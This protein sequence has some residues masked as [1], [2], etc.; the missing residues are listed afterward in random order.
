MDSC[1]NAVHVQFNNDFTLA[2]N[3]GL[4]ALKSTDLLFRFVSGNHR[5]A[6]SVSRYVLVE[7]NATYMY[8][9]VA[10]CN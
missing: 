7:D 8:I 10:I 1:L 5:D 9:T 2:Y 4:K 6:S 3:Y